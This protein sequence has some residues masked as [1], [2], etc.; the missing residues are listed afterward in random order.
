VATHHPAL[1][2]DADRVTTPPSRVRTGSAAEE[3]P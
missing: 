3:E 1:I 2:A